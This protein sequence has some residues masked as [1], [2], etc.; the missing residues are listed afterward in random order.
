[1]G[2]R[3]VISDIH[4]C[5]ETFRKL[6]EDIIRLTPADDVWLLGDY[7]DRGPN[8]SGVLDYILSL[9]KKA[10]KIHPLRGNHEE[11]LLK[12][13]E[14]YDRDTFRFY[15][16]KFKSLDLLD[17][18]SNIKP[19]YHKF[20][21]TLPYYAELENFYIVHA[22]FDIKKPDPFKDTTGMLEIRNMIYNSAVLKNKKIIHGHNPAYYEEI[23]T[24]VSEKRQII[25]LD[26][27]CIYHKP[28]K[29]YDH[30]RLGKLCCLDLDTFELFIQEYC[31]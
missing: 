15:V 9:I 27:G 17:E 5:S 21:N 4:G 20:I 25:P 23:L 3:L 10:Y 16:A 1:M 19:V 13:D 26:N 30:T 2:R 18:T 11:N 8:S 7:I 31:G 24:A 14:E 22:G 28:H 29:I 12:A 6:V